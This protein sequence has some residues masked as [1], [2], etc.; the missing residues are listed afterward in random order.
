MR[1]RSAVLALSI[2]G[3]LQQSTI[4]QTVP[5]PP[6]NGSF[7]GP[8][9]YTVTGRIKKLPNG[10]RPAGRVAFPSLADPSTLKITLD[11]DA[12][13]GQ[14]PIYSVEIDGDGTVQYL[15][16]GFVAVAGKHTSKISD[17]AVRDLIALFRGADFFWLFDRYAASV[18]DNPTYR[19]GIAFD[20]KKKVVEDYVGAAV[21]MPQSVTDLEEAID[22][23][24]GVRKWVAGDADTM[25][26]LRAEG[27]D[28][29]VNDDVHL[30]LLETAA[31]SNTDL[32]EKLLA[33]GVSAKTRFGCEALSAAADK[34]DTEA[35]KALTGAGA[36]THWAAGTGDRNYPCEALQTAAR[37]GV[38]EIIQFI[39]NEH[40]DVNA[41][42][43][44]GTTALMELA[45]NDFVTTELKGQNFGEAARLLIAA[46]ADVN[47]RDQ[48]G[49]SAIMKAHYDPGLVRILLRSGA[50]DIN[51][52]DALGRTP[53]MASTD[54]DV[55]QALLEAG[56]DP[57]LKD[58]DGKTTLDWADERNKDGRPVL[59]R[60]MTAHPQKQP[61]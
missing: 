43:E 37:R 33:A 44:S 60:W 19:V 35:I 50:T 39:L 10:G 34:G 49:E 27:W 57:Y 18:T 25:D 12:C 55:S 24:A 3:S 36:P 23:A 52:L 59:E 32:V 21:G 15:G 48:R 2:F 46:G 14:C 11:R 28:F 29:R 6:A 40:P 7:G 53:L 56:A 17:Q 8:A 58:V 47:A 13:F 1:L 30:Q 26:S 9:A 54:P 42:D 5:P 38:P 61:N 31:L 20:G 22:R 45:G 51:R 4:A 41:T 16:S